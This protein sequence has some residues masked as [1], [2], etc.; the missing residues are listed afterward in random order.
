MSTQ[1]HL[2]QMRKNRT[3]LQK[4]ELNKIEISN[5]SDAELKHW[6]SGCSRNSLA[7]SKA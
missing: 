4:E 3:K 2:A 7:T 1:R 5:L 6:L